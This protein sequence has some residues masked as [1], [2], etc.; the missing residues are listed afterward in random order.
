[1]GQRHQLFVIARIGR[2]YRSL[3][4]VHHQWLYGMTAIRICLRLLRGFGDPANH[5]ALTRELAVAA[6][7]YESHPPPKSG[8]SGADWN[9]PTQPFPFIMTCL[10]VGASCDPDSGYCDHVSQEAFGMAF[11]E[12]DNNNGITI[13]DITDP[14]APRYCF[15]DFQGME[16]ERRVP[17]DTPLSAWTYVLAYYDRADVMVQSS[18]DVMRAIDPFPL[19]DIATLQ[20]AWPGGEWKAALE[21]E[22]DTSGLLGKITRSLG[23]AFT[24]TASHLSSAHSAPGSIQA[25]DSITS[26]NAA[27]SGSLL[28]AS[29]TTLLEDA[30]STPDV[31]M[32][33]LDGPLQLSSFLPTMRNFL[34][35]HCDRVAQSPSAVPLLQL[36]FA[37]QDHVDLSPFVGLSVDK[38][39]AVLQHPSVSEAVQVVSFPVDLS[40]SPADLADALPHRHLT[41][42]YHIGDVAGWDAAANSSFFA[43]LMA[44]TDHSVS[45][46]VV[47]SMFR[48][49]LREQSWLPHSDLSAPAPG[50]ALQLMYQSPEEYGD[51]QVVDTFFL[52]D[53]LLSPTRL[54]AGL[55]NVFRMHTQ[56]IGMGQ[57]KI[58]QFALALA[59]APPRLWPRDGIQ[60][61]PLPAEMLQDQRRVYREGNTK[62]MRDIL[63]ETWTPLVMRLQSRSARK[64][65][66]AV[67]RAKKT[68]RATKLEADSLTLDDIEVLG[69]EDFLERMTLGSSTGL[70]ELNKS[71]IE[72]AEDTTRYESGAVLPTVTVDAMSAGE[73]LS[74]MKKALAQSDE[75]PKGD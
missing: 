44:D 42:L 27:G 16:S 35:T 39:K 41:E 74:M 64:Y 28:S 61:S 3:A 53:A 12:G 17:L 34:V 4:A 68:I 69:L 23:A 50:Y 47:G 70:K 63:Q 31:D 18:M 7:Y 32:A 55:Y 60:V 1:M 51:G 71:F 37:E 21:S 43:H 25:A 8:P 45:R 2:H 72:F 30:M 54:V 52:G 48:L 10:V 26:V 9:D 24:T 15:V 62:A 38:I 75:A 58:M 59:S 65:C 19:V 29:I 33:L 13:I 14:A 6:R 73:A 36:A 56:S 11:D 40:A 20:S 5:R 22:P 49:G 66:V 57:G 46:P 67:V